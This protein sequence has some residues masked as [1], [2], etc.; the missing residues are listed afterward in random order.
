MPEMNVHEAARAL[1]E[2]VESH[3]RIWVTVHESPDGDSIGAALALHGILRARGKQVVAIRQHPFPSQYESLPG[4]AAMADVRRLDEPPEPQVVI[5]VDVGSFQRIGGV[6]D[7]V[8]PETVVIN[9]D[10]H[11]GN[12]GP[13]RPCRLLNLVDPGFAS[14]TMLT[15]VLAQEAWPGCVD[16]ETARCLYVGLITDT[17]CFRFSNTDEEALRV[18]SEL[19]AL[20]ADPGALAEKYMFRRR[21][22]ALQLLAEVLASIEF[23]AEG[24]FATLRLTAD[25][26]R[27]TSARMDETEGFV[28]Y[29]TSLDGVHAAALFREV[30]PRLTRVSLR[31]SGLVDVARLAREFGGGGHMNAAGL[32]VEAALERA[33]E[34]VVQAA[35]RHLSAGRPA[36]GA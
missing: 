8:R 12:G 26:L 32:T 31:S 2:Q 10:H 36:E 24:R 14:T 15:Y 30:Q 13:E 11:A 4:A 3:Q 23:H 27:R 16:S 21:P 34:V 29:A 28:N 20:G 33:C 9:I 5:A 6:L 1:R 17:G 35:Q 18:G 7:R 22:Q 19:A 25:M